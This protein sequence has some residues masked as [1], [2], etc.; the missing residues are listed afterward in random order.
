MKNLIFITF[1]LISSIIKVQ[2]Q[3]RIDGFLG[4]PF[5]S[6]TGQVIDSMKTKGAEEDVAVNNQYNLTKI[7]KFNKVSIGGRTCADFTVT[8]VNDKAAQ[9]EFVFVPTESILLKYYDDIV[10]ELV[11]AYGTPEHSS[12]YY[13]N[14]GNNKRQEIAGLK[15]GEKVYTSTW[16]DESNSNMVLLSVVSDANYQLLVKLIY[17]YPDLYNQRQPTSPPQ[18]TNNKSSEF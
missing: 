9:A 18:Q 15:S 2:A 7:L 14:Y 16:T 1:L 11:K 5:G 6:Y 10:V 3:K 17:R 12:N 4:I 8:F 13:S